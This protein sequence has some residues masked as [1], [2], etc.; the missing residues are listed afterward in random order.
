MT[1]LYEMR[2][3][4]GGDPR[5]FDDF[6]ALH[7]ELA[8]LNHPACPDMDWARVEALCLRLFE[9]NGAELQ[10]AATYTLAR[11]QRHGLTG[12]AEGV[13]LIETLVGEWPLLWP[14]PA[15]ARLDILA[16]LFAQLQPRLRVLQLTAGCET[17]LSTLDAGLERLEMKLTRLAPAPLMTLGALREQVVNLMQRAQRSS[18]PALVI[19]QPGPLVEP[20]HGM[21]GMNPPCPRTPFVFVVQRAA[22]R[23]GLGIWLVAALAGTALAGWLGWEQWLAVEEPTPL[24]PA[25]LQ[26]DSLSLFDAGSSKLKADSTKALVNALVGIRARPGWLIVIA[27]HADASGD[28]AKNLELSRARAR[29]VR[30]WMQG[31]GDIPDSCFAIQGFAASQPVTSNETQTGRAANRRVD[32]RLV[33][34]AGAC[35]QLMAEDGSPA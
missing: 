21:P 11:S 17:T 29:A 23:R 8:R 13:A 14:T 22:K 20:A 33:P 5:G 15:A 19:H 3:R 1:T 24:I 32:I 28:V 12:M 30:D 26:L 6:T 2:L 18:A 31:M 7:H 4:L 16:W 25:P 9:Q 34:Q 35:G 27:G 10:T